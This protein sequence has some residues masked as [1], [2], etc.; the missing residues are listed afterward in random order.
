MS[1]GD[2][3]AGTSMTQT[4]TA[5]QIA[6]MYP[7]ESVKLPGSADRL[8]VEDLMRK[9]Q[10]QI[11]VYDNS[12][13]ASGIGP[14][15]F[16]AKHERFKRKRKKKG[17]SKSSKLQQAAETRLN[18]AGIRPEASEYKAVTGRK[19]RIDFAWPSV[20]VGL[21]IDGGVW[22]NEIK[23][24]NCHQTVKQKLKNGRMMT[25]RIGGR[26]N[27]GEGLMRELEKRALLAAEGWLIIAVTDRQ[28]KDGS[29]V[30]WVAQCIDNRRNE[31]G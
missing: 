26:H 9:K 13:M 7:N 17:G 29:M 31:N 11:F 21:E 20:K 22:G 3:G 27:R 25:V 14:E 28:I 19:F 2:S 16:M 1:C 30:R 12:G 18:E 8:S 4:L 15:E 24:H 23:C 10:N 5:E 6:E